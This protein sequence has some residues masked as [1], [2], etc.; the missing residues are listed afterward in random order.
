M[1][2]AVWMK[3]N[4]EDGRMGRWADGQSAGRAVQAKFSTVHFPQVGA[5]QLVEEDHLARVLVRLEPVADER[6]EL[7]VD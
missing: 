5:G 1:P 3:G 2:L 4:K 7:L 6:A